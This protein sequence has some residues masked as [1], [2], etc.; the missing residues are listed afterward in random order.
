[1]ANKNARQHN[2]AAHNTRESQN[3]R[4][5]GET[6]THD[7]STHKNNLDLLR[8]FF[9]PL[10]SA[11][12]KTDKRHNMTRLDGHVKFQENIRYFSA[13]QGQDMDFTRQHK[14]TP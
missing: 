3:T 9:C 2:T 11:T 5:Q 14:T 6:P 12:S 13:R 8:V 10:L 7:N 4:Q 1:M